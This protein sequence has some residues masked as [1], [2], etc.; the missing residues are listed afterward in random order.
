MFE[1]KKDIHTGERRKEGERSHTAHTDGDK[2][3]G[4]KYCHT[5]PF[6]TDSL[7]QAQPCTTTCPIYQLECQQTVPLKRSL[8]CFPAWSSDNAVG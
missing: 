3:K 1:R 2:E 6:S 5:I 8:K 4:G 7:E